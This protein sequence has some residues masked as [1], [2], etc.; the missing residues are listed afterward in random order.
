M[1]AALN[2]EKALLGAFSVIVKSSPK[3]R[4]ELYWGD[5]MRSYL[6]LAATDCGQLGAADRML[7]RSWDGDRGNLEQIQ[8]QVYLGSIETPIE[9]SLSDCAWKF[10][11][12]VT[13]M[14]L[15]CLYDLCD[16]YEPSPATRTVV[17][18]L[19]RI[20][21]PGYCWV[22]VTKYHIFAQIPQIGYPALTQPNTATFLSTSR[23]SR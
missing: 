15:F 16:E 6:L 2:Q 20:H 23:T 14:R 21:H 7:T 22:I 4:C 18:R 1:V 5:E 8:Y 19:K 9:L 10:M 11:V 17:T 3:V 13:V 12:D